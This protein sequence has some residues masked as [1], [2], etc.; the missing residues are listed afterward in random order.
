MKSTREIAFRLFEE[1]GKV[2]SSILNRGAPRD[3]VEY[4][5]AFSTRPINIADLETEAALSGDL[6]W[7]AGCAVREPDGRMTSVSPPRFRQAVIDEMR[8]HERGGR[9]L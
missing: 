7:L 5:D 4:P 2:N 9:Q 8:L 1:D 3:A 6:T